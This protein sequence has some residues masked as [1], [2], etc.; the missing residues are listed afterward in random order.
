MPCPLAAY[1]EHWR[2]QSLLG[3]PGMRREKRLLKVEIPRTKPGE[4]RAASGAGGERRPGLIQRG[5][6]TRITVDE[7]VVVGSPPELGLLRGQTAIA[8]FPS[9]HPGPAPTSSPLGPWVPVP[10]SLPCSSHHEWMW[11]L[12]GE[13]P[14]GCRWS[15]ALAH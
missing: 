1:M 6:S 12:A 2:E 13:E 14:C 10:C 7:P 11:G 9:P 8:W 5:S 4:R 15:W 3:G